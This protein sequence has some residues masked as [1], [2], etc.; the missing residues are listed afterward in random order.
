M[1]IIFHVTKRQYRYQSYSIIYLYIISI[2]KHIN[3]ITNCVKNKVIFFIHV[4]FGDDISTIIRPNTMLLKFIV[5]SITVIIN[6]KH[7]TI[8]FICSLKFKLESQSPSILFQNFS[9]EVSYRRNK[10]RF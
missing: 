9:E 7:E 8:T 6:N 1:L 5:N 2:N 4:K 3:T 10:F